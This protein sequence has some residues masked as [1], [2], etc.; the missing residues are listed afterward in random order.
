M[1]NGYDYGVTDERI[2]LL[3]LHRI[4]GERESSMAKSK[5]KV[6]D[7]VRFQIFYRANYRC[8]KCGGL[9]DTFGW[10]VHHRVPRRMGGSRNE[11][12]HLP[13]NLILLC[14]SGVSGCHGWVESY[15]DKAR[16]RGF[17]LTKV[18]SAEEI[19][20]IDDNG[21]AWQIFNNGEKWKFDR[22][23]SDPYL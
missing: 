4:F 11:T 19:P 1:Q 17:L 2:Y 3:W 16:E 14:G 6:G 21:K 12:L 20:F 9:G 18:E 23:S 22:S 5:L 13:A 7:G 10:S 8:E 15:R